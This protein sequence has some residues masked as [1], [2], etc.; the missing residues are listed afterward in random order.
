M[1]STTPLSVEI[2]SSDFLPS[3]LFR[4][5]NEFIKNRDRVGMAFENNEIRLYGVWE[6]DIENS[7]DA[8]AKHLKVKLRVK[9]LRIEYVRDKDDLMEPVLNL[10]IELEEEHLGELTGDLMRR[11]GLILSMEDT[12]KGRKS[13]SSLVPL[14]ELI[15]YSAYL[16][17]ASSQ[18]GRAVAYFHGYQICPNGRGPDPDEPASMVLRA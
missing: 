2:E 9:N 5:A 12:D 14:S 18:K 6:P 1:K 10:V 15:G 11:R 3:E 4:L 8:M 13:I 7:L 17:N 16:R